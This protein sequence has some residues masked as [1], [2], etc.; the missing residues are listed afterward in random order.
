MWPPIPN[1]I[2][3]SL[4]DSGIKCILLKNVRN[5]FNVNLF[6]A[7]FLKNVQEEMHIY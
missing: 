4:V 5:I 6:H 3:I 2:E 1:F 7:L